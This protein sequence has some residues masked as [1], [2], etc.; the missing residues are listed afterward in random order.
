M[1]KPKEL[2]HL[3]FY[4]SEV[5][6]APFVGYQPIQIKRAEYQYRKIHQR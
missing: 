3:T 1:R 6:E 5:A 4:H 2:K